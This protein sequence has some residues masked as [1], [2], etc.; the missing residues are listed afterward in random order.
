[1]QSSSLKSSAS[2]LENIVL[3]L[4]STV[5]KLSPENSKRQIDQ[6]TSTAIHFLSNPKLAQI[7][8]VHDRISEKEKYQRER[9]KKSGKTFE[10]DSLL[11]DLK[12]HDIEFLSETTH[13]V[14]LLKAHESIVSKNFNLPDLKDFFTYTDYNL[15][16]L[17]KLPILNHFDDS[18]PEHNISKVTKGFP[19]KLVS[20][21]KSNGEKL[22][23]TIKENE[24]GQ[25]TIARVI[26]G[27]KADLSGLVHPGD[28]ILEI[29]GVSLEGI[30]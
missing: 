4:P 14:K 18:I 20:L 1:M 13:L 28:V 24:N 23:V 16:Q 2:A 5:R 9:N 15:M 12:Q 10:I 26:K 21:D 19:S 6:D 22:G 25:I 29:N 8:Q 27:D 30:F 7:L 17:E 3:D 11:S